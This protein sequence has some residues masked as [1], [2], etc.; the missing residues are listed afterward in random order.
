M[1]AAEDADLNHE[2]NSSLEVSLSWSVTNVA[3]IL[4]AQPGTHPSRFLGLGIALSAGHSETAA[5]QIPNL[6]APKRF[7][8]VALGGEGFGN[9]L[10]CVILL[11]LLLLHW[12][13]LSLCDVLVQIS[14][15]F[16]GYLTGK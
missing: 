15:H 12:P 2:Y 10:G 13:A 9:T 5:W 8:P 16:V 14:W 6:G 4:R 3:H 1:E 11:A 7:V